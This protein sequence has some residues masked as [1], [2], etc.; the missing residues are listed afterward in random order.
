MQGGLMYRYGQRSAIIYVLVMDEQPKT[1]SFIPPAEFQ[2]K[3]LRFISYLPKDLVQISDSLTY[4]ELV[5]RNGLDDPYHFHVKYS[6][7]L[8]EYLKVMPANR[9]YLFL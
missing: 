9:P 5:Q 8:E 7:N 6:V 4:Y 1:H 2:N 3:I